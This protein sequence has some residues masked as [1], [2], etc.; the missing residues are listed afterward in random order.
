[1]RSCARAVANSEKKAEK[2]A[3]PVGL[4][5]EGLVG[6]GGECDGVGQGERCRQREG[7]ELHGG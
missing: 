2:K 7:R 3:W 1:M 4:A 6:V 5:V